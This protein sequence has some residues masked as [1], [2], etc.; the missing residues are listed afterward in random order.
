MKQVFS[1]KISAR[2]SS[3]NQEG[4]LMGEQISLPE[5]EKIGESICRVATTYLPFA[6]CRMRLRSVIQKI[7]TLLYEKYM[8]NNNFRI[9]GAEKPTPSSPPEEEVKEEQSNSR[10]FSI[11][12]KS[13]TKNLEEGKIE[14]LNNNIEDNIEADLLPVADLDQIAKEITEEDLTVIEETKSNNSSDDDDDFSSTESEDDIKRRLLH[15]NEEENET[16]KKEE[17]VDMQSE[18]NY[19]NSQLSVVSRTSP[20]T[21]SILKQ[22]I[23]SHFALSKK[24][25][26]TVPKVSQ[27][28]RPLSR[29]VK[30]Q[31]MRSE[32]RKSL[33]SYNQMPKNES[34]PIHLRPREAPLKITRIVTSS[35]LRGRRNNNNKIYTEDNA[36][37]VPEYVWNVVNPQSEIKKNAVNGLSLHGIGIFC[38]GSQQKRPK[39]LNKTENLKN[40]KSQHQTTYNEGFPKIFNHDEHNSQSRSP[41]KKEIEREYDKRSLGEFL[42]QEAFL[43]NLNIGKRNKSNETKG[44]S[45]Q[46][47]LRQL[48]VNS[49]ARQKVMQEKNPFENC[50]FGEPVQ[51]QKR[52]KGRF[53]QNKI[54][55]QQSTIR[56]L[57]SKETSTIF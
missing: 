6:N 42:L 22:E 15:R 46:E 24:M 12:I 53:S 48:L 50:V 56:N 36:V 14:D 51:F 47:K 27:M 31:S 17:K 28:K 5:Y 18:D 41:Q 40:S 45:N 19:T 1:G 30:E 55:L 21:Q 3:S 23:I 32:S 37:S 44:I 10:P 9:P 20:N 39:K 43:K 16:P 57:T 33:F 25:P 34:K 13:S 2:L 54:Q 49:A 8:K 38:G 26:Q 11:K 35:T 4:P 29:A 7:S 52:M